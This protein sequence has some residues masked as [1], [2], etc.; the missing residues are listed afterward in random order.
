M[1]MMMMMMM[2]MMMMMMIE[3]AQWPAGRA[4]W[5]IIDAVA[6]LTYRTN[7]NSQNVSQCSD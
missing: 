1:M 3:L 5:H 7:T 4:K 6:N 2:V